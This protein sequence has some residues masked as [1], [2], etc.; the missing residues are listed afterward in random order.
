MI[1]IDNL[2]TEYKKFSQAE[3]PKVLQQKNFDNVLDFIEEYGEDR[4]IDRAVDTFI[5]KLNEV[6][7]SHNKPKPENQKE[8]K[9]K[10]DVP[11][12]LPAPKGVV[13][14]TE[15]IKMIKRYYLMNGKEKTGHQ[16]LLFINALQKSI[17][18]KRIRKTSKYAP[19]INHIQKSLLSLYEDYSEDQELL[20]IE[21]GQAAVTKYK[22]IVSSEQILHS[23]KFIKRFI[24]IQG[25]K[26]VKDKAKRLLTQMRKANTDGVLSPNKSIDEIFTSLNKYIDGKTDTPEITKIQLSGLMGLAGV[27][28]KK[29]PPK[30]RGLSGADDSEETEVII[31][32]R[33]KI[34]ADNRNYN[35]GNRG[36]APPVPVPVEKPKT[37][38]IMNSQRLEEMQFDQLG[39][40]GVWLDVLGPVTD[41]FYMMISGK[42]GSGKSTLLALLAKYFGKDLN[43][44]VLYVSHEEGF[45][46][47]LQDKFKRCDAFH[48]NIDIT[49]AMPNDVSMYD[50]VIVDSVSTLHME[51]E[52]VQKFIFD[53]RK[54]NT[55]LALV[56]HA[57]KDGQYKGMSENEHLV[58]MT[59]ILDAGITQMGHKN[60]FGGKG[61]M[62]VFDYC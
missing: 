13:I 19:E 7:K 6:S 22:E 47:T 56:Y 49:E 60:R 14:P 55:S 36:E 27:S 29:S 53:S 33:S 11:S 26:D 48:A 51:V 39:V 3:L 12:N 35:Q 17:I 61:Q 31:H 57:T 5:E 9:A 4:D 52:D 42:P 15:E 38:G 43:R 34:P 18:E 1:T 20:T 23:V 28:Q 37:P 16:I 62:N 8:T 40:K 24:G 30:K 10:K 44:K 21:I 50:L 41:P 25:K 45:A 58:D 59:L 46:S 32:S 54:T 2:T